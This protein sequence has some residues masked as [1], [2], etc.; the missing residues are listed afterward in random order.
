VT[1]AE[2]ELIQAQAERGRAWANVTYLFP[3][4]NEQ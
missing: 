3:G 1:E 4:E 2:I